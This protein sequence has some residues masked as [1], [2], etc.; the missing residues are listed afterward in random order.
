MFL[1]AAP[2]ASLPMAFFL[3]AVGMLFIAAFAAPFLAPKMADWIYQQEILALVHTLTLGFLL[4]VFLGASVQ[5]LPVVS[6]VLV[7]RTGFVRVA[8]VLYFAG[9]GGMVLHFMKLRWNGLLFSASAVIVA[10]ALFFTAALPVLRKARHDPVRLAFVLGYAGLALTMTAGLLI[11]LDRRATFLPGGPMDHLAA[12][13]TLGLL[14]TF[15]VAIWGVTSKLLPMFLV[16]PTPGPR[17]QK[18]ALVLLWSGSVLLAA[19]LWL[20]LPLAPFA[21]LP[22]AGFALQ[23]SLLKDMVGGRRRGEIDTGFRYALSAYADLLAAGGVGLLIAFGVGKGTLLSLR[24][25]WVYGFLLLVGWVLQ[26]VVGILSKILPFLVWQAVYARAV[27]LSPV[28]KLKDLSSDRL[29]AAGFVLFRIATILMAL[30][31]FRARVGEL[32][33]AGALLA[34]SL[35]PFAAHVALVLSHLRKPRSLPAPGESPFAAAG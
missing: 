23:V 4:A 26:T 17:R 12:H 34:V 15:T 7:T 24:L 32:R 21:V 28:P 22:A 18:A 25:P 20:R 11:G 3:P 10:V 19:A 1:S 13:L 8:A 27:G 29:Q 14:A 35:L 2:A 33:V 31:L 16:A 5:L 6:G 30:A 9:V